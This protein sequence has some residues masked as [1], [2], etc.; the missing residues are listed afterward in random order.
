[1]VLNS[2]AEKEAYEKLNAAKNR[3]EAAKIKLDS[4]NDITEYDQVS[5]KIITLE[6][7]ILELR[8][9]LEMIKSKEAQLVIDA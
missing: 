6:R 3:L 7:E 1:M 4:A 5:S 9:R 2:K 8:S